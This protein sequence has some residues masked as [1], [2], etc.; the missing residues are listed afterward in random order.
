M[1]VWAPPLAAKVRVEQLWLITSS[2]QE[3]SIEVEVATALR[4][5]QLGLMFRT[6]L[7]DEKGMLFPYESPQ[8]V[9]MWMRNTYI[10]LDMVFIRAD[11]VVHRIEKRA[12]PMSE[13]IIASDGEVTAVLE[14]AGGAADRL[15]LK[16]GDRVRHPHFSASAP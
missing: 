4:E 1:L 12:E 10:P 7:A 5:K 13:R 8:E 6:E 14:L 16:V 9:T 3:H 15:G 2:G 11:G